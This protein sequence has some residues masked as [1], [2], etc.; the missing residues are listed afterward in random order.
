MRRRDNRDEFK[1]CTRCSHR[2]P[3]SAFYT[4]GSRLDSI[5]KKC[6]KEMARST[7]LTRKHRDSYNNLV[8]FVG[9]MCELECRRIDRTCAYLDQIIRRNSANCA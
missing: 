3:Q 9:L 8:K 4:K 2:L 1:N 5:C 6:K 7:Y